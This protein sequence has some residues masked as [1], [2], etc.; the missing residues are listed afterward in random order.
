MGKHDV[1]ISGSFAIQFFERVTW[2][3]SDLDLYAQAGSSTE[4]LHKYLC[5]KEGYRV[6]RK[7]GGVDY[8][9]IDDWLEVRTSSI[10]IAKPSFPCTDLELDTNIH[11]EEGRLHRLPDSDCEHGVC[12]DICHPERFLL[13][14]RG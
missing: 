6:N 11:E 13:D 5:E 1:L 12:A 9:P 14:P 3:E 2:K 4:A 10:R 8:W 7:T